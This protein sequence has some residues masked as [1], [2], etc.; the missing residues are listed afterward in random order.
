MEVR[1]SMH[2]LLFVPPGD[3]YPWV[4]YV[5]VSAAGDG[6]WFPQFDG[7]YRVELWLPAANDPRLAV[8]RSADK[9]RENAPAVLDAFLMQLVGDDG[10]ASIAAL[11]DLGV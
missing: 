9:A 5:Q 2:D 7:V 1:T 10:A 6:F 11:T 4:R 3:R 8:L